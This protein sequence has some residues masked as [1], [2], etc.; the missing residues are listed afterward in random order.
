MRDLSDTSPNREGCDFFQRA[1]GTAWKFWRSNGN[2]HTT[3]FDIT[4][5]AYTVGQWCHLVAV[6]NATVPSATLYLNGVQVAQSTTPNGAFAPN[7]DFP[8]SIGGYSDASQNPF[9]GDMDEVAVYTNALSSGEVLAHYQNGT[10]ASRSA[11]YNSLVQSDNPVE[12][13]RFNEPAHNTAVNSGTLGAAADGV[14]DLNVASGVLGPQPTNNAGF[15]SSNTAAFFNGAN[16]Y[17]ELRNPS[18]LNFSGQVT[19]EAWVQPSVT[20]AAPGGFGDIIAHGFDEDY[21]EVA[22][23]VDDSSG[24]PQYSISTYSVAGGGEGASAAVPQAD[25]GSGAWVHLVGTYDGVNWNLYRDGV[26]I[27]SQPDVTGSLMVNNGNWAVGAR[28][29]WAHMDALTPSLNRQFQGKIDEPA[30]Y[31]YALTPQQVASHYYIGAFNTTNVPLAILTQ[32]ASQRVMTN[33]AA[34]FSVV[35]SGNPL[36]GYQW[37]KVVGGTTNPIAGANT[38]S[39]TTSSVQDSDSGNGYFVVATN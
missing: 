39:Y 3:V 28:G 4:G 17:V 26:L 20:P 22:L 9:I 36:P 31:N 2:A 16:S 12:Y 27:A 21:N 19:L 38:A 30:I 23:R 24:T 5:V 34:T 11:S 37:Y 13:L 18:A 8:L 14:Y 29:R 15:E 1:S 6:Y 33:T 7:G 35:V 25:L 32:P 10:N